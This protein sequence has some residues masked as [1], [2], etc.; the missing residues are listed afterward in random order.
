MDKNDLSFSAQSS[1]DFEV[2]IFPLK[3]NTLKQKLF[4]DIQHEV[5][6]RLRL[7]RDISQ[8]NHPSPG[9]RPSK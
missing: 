8:D 9:S 2:R 6:A 1:R 3:L 7:S 5:E 4:Q